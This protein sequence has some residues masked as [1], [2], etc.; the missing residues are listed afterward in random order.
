MVT[1]TTPDKESTNDM[2]FRVKGDSS[3]VL[4]WGWGLPKE[5]LFERFGLLSM[6]HSATKRTMFKPR[7]DAQNLATRYI[8]HTLLGVSWGLRK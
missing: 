2:R 1:L 8:P 4:S 7:V 5:L 3:T 6:L